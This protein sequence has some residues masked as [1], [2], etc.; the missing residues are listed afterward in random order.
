MSDSLLLNIVRGIGKKFNNSFGNPY[1]PLGI[2]WF[3][4]RLLK[5]AAVDKPKTIG[6]LD[7]SISFIKNEDFLHS[8]REIFIDHIYRQPAAAN[9]LILDCGANIGL[10]VIYLKKLFPDATI[11]AFEPDSLNFSLLQQNMAHFGFRN[12]ELR[13]EAIYSENTWLDFSSSGDLG[14]RIEQGSGGGQVKG[15]RLKDLLNREITFLKLD[16]EGAEYKVLMDAGDAI[17]NVGRLFIEYHG[18]FAQN[19]ELNEILQLITRNG[20]RYYIKEAA[21]VYKTP[22]KRKPGKMFDVQLNI[23]CFRDGDETSLAK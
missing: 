22:F 8:L 7:K 17:R 15:V 14:S 5:N 19:A 3:T 9:A 12:V 1:R 6:F 4:M 2:G 16:I 10:S 18:S 23:F 13:Q 20:F 11:I 21:E